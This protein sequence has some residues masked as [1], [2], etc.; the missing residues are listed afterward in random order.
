MLLQ[1]KVFI[2]SLETLAKTDPYESQVPRYCSP[3]YDLAFGGL[4]DCETFEW[5]LERSLPWERNQIELNKKEHSRSSN[6]I[7]LNVW[8]RQLMK[9]R[10]VCRW[11]ASTKQSMGLWNNYGHH[12]V[13]VLSSINNIRR[14]LR[15]RAPIETSDR[16]SLARRHRCPTRLR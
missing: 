12:G 16:C 9:Q 8:L 4:L 5:L 6:S 15:L 13:A 1:G 3:D 7:L 10:L 2:P 14:A 11:H